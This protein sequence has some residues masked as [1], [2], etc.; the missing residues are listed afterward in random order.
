MHEESKLG[1]LR[2]IQKPGTWNAQIAIKD[3]L[4]TNVESDIVMGIDLGL[5]VPAVCKTFNGQTKFS[6]NV[7]MNKFFKRRFR[8][9]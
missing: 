6:G 5:K 4:P 7:R 1:A 9:V 3:E 8:A 2:I